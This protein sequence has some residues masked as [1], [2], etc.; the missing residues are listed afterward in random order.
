MVARREVDDALADRFDDA[1]RLVAEDAGGRHGEAALD[2]VEV[3]V[4][5]TGGGGLQE[6][7]ARTRV[8]DANLLELE[9]GMVL[10]HYGCF[11]GDLL[12]YSPL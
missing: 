7:L 5:D 2:H 6:D 8:V 9:G 3:A 12:G 1:R 4:T 11:H 10:A